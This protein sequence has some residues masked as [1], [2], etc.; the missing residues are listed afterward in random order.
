MRKRK[1]KPLTLA[2]VRQLAF[3]PHERAMLDEAGRKL[4]TKTDKVDTST[5]KQYSDTED[6]TDGEV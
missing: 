2:Q 6:M 3:T 5:E 4:S 1:Q